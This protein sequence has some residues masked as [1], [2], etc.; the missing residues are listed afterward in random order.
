[1]TRHGRMVT[2]V[3]ILAVACILI[4][5]GIFLSRQSNDQIKNPSPS[6]EA[7]QAASSQQAVI[8]EAQ[9]M[10]GPY[11]GG[12][13][14][15]A[16]IK[17]VSVRYQY[18]SQGTLSA[19]EYPILQE[20][21]KED[22]LHYSIDISIPQL[23]G[24]SDDVRTV[25]EEIASEFQEILPVTNDAELL[26][27]EA[28]A[29]TRYHVRYFTTQTDKTVS[30]VVCST[31]CYAD[32]S[33]A[34]DC[35]VYN[36]DRTSWKRLSPQEILTVNGID[37]TVIEK[38][39]NQ[40]FSGSNYQD[41]SSP[42][43]YVDANDVWGL[44]PSSAGVSRVKLTTDQ[45]A[46]EQ[47]LSILDNLLKRHD[48]LTNHLFRTQEYLEIP[49]G[50]VFDPKQYYP[51]TDAEFSSLD[52]YKEYL[53]STYT[54]DMAGDLAI[55]V[56]LSALDEPNPPVY[57]QYGRLYFCQ[58]RAPQYADSTVLDFS[59]YTASILDFIDDDVYF[60]VTV[61]QFINGEK[62]SATKTVT[63]SYEDGAWKISRIS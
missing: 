56:Y 18:S 48:K 53:R 51:V 41:F 37:A 32:G 62:F 30:V 35:L 5:A 31:V 6:I 29:T 63:I 23:E 1:M 21:A 50:E 43:Y 60:N 49:K 57:E 20:K 59:N 27:T 19:E 55:G 38:M 15:S 22:T 3:V 61:P 4:A 44:I 7:V 36:F 46:D 34:E 10:S 13:I 2:T 14:Q 12:S 47:Y 54:F 58:A 39:Y 42:S 45:A 26:L 17:E 8:N 52:R 11:G 9:L 40:K 28:G 25:N 16:S 33:N 24:E